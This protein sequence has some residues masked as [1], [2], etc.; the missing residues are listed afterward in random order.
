[1]DKDMGGLRRPVA[2]PS[3]GTGHPLDK[4][5]GLPKLLE[6]LGSQL[7]P[8]ALDQNGKAFG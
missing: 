5:V 6:L 3:H 2:R 1:M 8:R 4:V 7:Q